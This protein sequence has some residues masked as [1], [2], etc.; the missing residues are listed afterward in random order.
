M[1]S[2]REYQQPHFTTLL[3]S[4]LRDGIAHDGSDTGTGKTF[5]GAALA[6]VIGGR[7][8]IVCPLSV[9]TTWRDTLEAFGVGGA[10]VVNYEKAWRR[11]GRVQPHGKG[12]YFI[13]NSDADFVLFDEGHRCGGTTSINSKLLIAARRQF[14]Y[15][16]TSSAT[17]ADTPLRMKAFGFMMGLHGL[18]RPTHET[19][20]P[21]WEKFL[22]KCQAKP[23]RFGGWT[24]SKTKH[25]GVMAALHELIYGGPGLVARGS[26][27]IRDEI[28]GFPKTVL[29]VRTFDCADRGVAKLGAELQEHYNERIL[30]AATIESRLKELRE[31]ALD[32]VE[33][34]AV[35]RRMAGQGLARLTFLRQAMETAKIPMVVDMIEDALEDGKVAVF[36]NFNLTIDELCRAAEKKGWKYGVIRGMTVIDGKERR[37][38]KEERKATETAFQRNELDVIFCNLEA[39]GVGMSLHDPL[40][41]VMRTSVILP[42]FS[43]RAIQQAR[44]RVH[45]LDGGFSRQ[46]FVYFNFGVEAQM[47]RAVNASIANLDLLN[48]QQLY[49]IAA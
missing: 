18:S 16:M 34:E 15:V 24:W 41:Q 11:C 48:D 3:S 46:Y 43:A 1:A 26:R 30:K 33:L 45:R 39:G 14:S 10:D 6:S 36:T 2:L 21:D 49:G 35:E 20:L 29:S 42:A 32:E 23:G 44:G 27:M 17:I 47:A 9:V 22:L 38:T 13:W 8:R 40:T 28:P 4:L 25:P 37:Q 19:G 12:S 31:N 5:V 7:P